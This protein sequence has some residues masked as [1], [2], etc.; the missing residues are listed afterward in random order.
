MREANIIGFQ[1][2][3]PN[4]ERVIQWICPDCGA[5]SIDYWDIDARGGFDGPCSPI[6]EDHCGYE[7][8]RWELFELAESRGAV[9]LR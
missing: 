1:P 7:A 4:G 2:G 3:Q 6:C 9:A 8:D 5:Y